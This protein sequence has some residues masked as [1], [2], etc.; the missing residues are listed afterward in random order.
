MMKIRTLRQKTS[1]SCPM[2]SASPLKLYYYQ[3]C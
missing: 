3:R 1:Y 2:K